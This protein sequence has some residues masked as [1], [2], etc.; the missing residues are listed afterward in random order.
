[1]RRYNLL[2]FILLFALYFAGCQA[3]SENVQK[4]FV[5]V[6]DQREEWS[7]T[8]NQNGILYADINGDGQD[9]TVKITYEELEGAQ[10]IADFNVNI[11]G[12]NG[13]FTVEEQYD[14]SFIKMI[15]YDVD[16]DDADE[17]ILLFDTHGGGGEGTHDIYILWMGKDGIK[18]EIIN[19]YVTDIKN[20]ETSW[21]FDGIYNIEKVEI[22]GEENL[23]AYQYVWGENGHSDAVGNIISLVSYQSGQNAFSAKQSWMENR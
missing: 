21:N 16:K 9:D 1:M 4:E 23:L 20:A 2:V 7:K 8:L 11:S 14:A 19:P 6:K 18:K 13:L 22:N 10:Y 5:P 17:L 3:E 15:L 12:L